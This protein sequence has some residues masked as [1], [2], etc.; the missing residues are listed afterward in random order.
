[1]GLSVF[2]D[3]FFSLSRLLAGEGR[4]GCYWMLGLILGSSPR[5]KGPSMTNCRPARMS[6]RLKECGALPPLRA[7]KRPFRKTAGATALHRR[8][9]AH[10]H[11][12]FPNVPRIISRSFG[13]HPLGGRAIVLRTGV[14]PTAS[15]DRD[16][17]DRGRRRRP[18]PTFS[19][20]IRTTPPSRDRVI[21]YMPYLRNLVKHY[22]DSPFFASLGP[23]VPGLDPG[24]NTRVQLDARLKAEHS[25]SGSWIPAFAGVTMMKRGC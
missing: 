1:M 21:E 8:F 7:R 19:G 5:T 10:R 23:L 3:S 2:C 16:C 24:I 6:L 9:W 4:W 20:D 22:F 14:L 12:T 11:A 17:L 13:N 25:N 15:R 18:H